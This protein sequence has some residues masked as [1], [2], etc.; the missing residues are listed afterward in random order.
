MCFLGRVAE[1]SSRNMLDTADL[2]LV[3]FKIEDLYN[4]VCTDFRVVHDREAL[5]CCYYQSR[6]KLQCSQ[7]KHCKIS[8][9][10]MCTNF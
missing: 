10:A 3:N 5:S 1:N 8:Q 7:I 2:Q 9:F 6:S 4:R